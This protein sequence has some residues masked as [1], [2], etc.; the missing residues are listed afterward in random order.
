MR[1]YKQ[2]YRTFNWINT[3]QII[4]TLSLKQTRLPKKRWHI[5]SSFKYGPTRKI[6]LECLSFLYVLW[7]ATDCP[8][9]RQKQD[10]RNRQ[11]QRVLTRLLTRFG[12]TCL[13][14]L[15][16]PPA[17]ILSAFRPCVPIP[18]AALSKAW[19]CGCSLAEIVGSNTARSM[20]VWVLCAHR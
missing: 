15:R 10:T 14:I 11:A 8:I 2:Y 18:V 20:D 3:K 9:I 7:F 1:N 17:I 19:V 6:S 5:R 12:T 16:I 4:K 13:K